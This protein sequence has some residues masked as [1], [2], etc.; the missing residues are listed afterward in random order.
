MIWLDHVI[1]AMFE[2][3]ENEVA[4]LERHFRVLEAVAEHEPVGPITVSN[5]VAYPQHK[6]RYSLRV[7]ESEGLAESTASGFT[8]TDRV[9]GF[10]D[11]F[12]WQL[13]DIARV[14]ECNHVDSQ[15]LSV[16]TSD[17]VTAD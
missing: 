4:I 7:L 12:D 1:Y 17:S 15:V 13:D 2:R 16:A 8:T 11:R 6:V 14:L 3:V 5:R 10:R 9:P